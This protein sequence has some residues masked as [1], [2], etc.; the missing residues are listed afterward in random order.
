[1]L[2]SETHSI[3][4]VGIVYWETTLEMAG[5]GVTFRVVLHMGIY[6]GLDRESKYDKPFFKETGDRKTIA[7]GLSVIY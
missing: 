5:A 7:D 1:M 2:I 4:A 3:S 6:Y